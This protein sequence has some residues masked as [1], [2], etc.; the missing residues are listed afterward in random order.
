[1]RDV[2]GLLL[3]DEEQT[4]VRSPIVPQTNLKAQVASDSIKHQLKEATMQIV[5]NISPPMENNYLADVEKEK[6][7]GEEKIIDESVEKLIQ[8]SGKSFQTESVQKRSA[9]EEESLGMTVSKDNWQQLNLTGRSSRVAHAEKVAKRRQTVDAKQMTQINQALEETKKCK[10]KDAQKDS[11]VDKLGLEKRDNESKAD[12]VSRKTKESDR[13]KGLKGGVKNEK[14]TS[15]GD[16]SRLVVSSE[17]SDES[18]SISS[19]SDDGEVSKD[20]IMYS[21]TRDSKTEE[22]NVKDAKCIKKRELSSTIDRPVVTR[23]DSEVTENFERSTKVLEAKDSNVI[24]LSSSARRLSESS[25][26]EVNGTEKIAKVSGEKVELS[27]RESTVLPLSKTADGLDT[28][29]SID[30]VLQSDTISEMSAKNLTQTATEKNDDKEFAPEKFA[31]EKGDVVPE[32]QII[33]VENV[34]SIESHPVGNIESHPENISDDY[35]EDKQSAM[36]PPFTSPKIEQERNNPDLQSGILV[37]SMT[38]NKA[39][40]TEKE[41]TELPA[42]DHETMDEVM[43]NVGNSEVVASDNGADTSVGNKTDENTIGIEEREWGDVSLHLSDV[44]VSPSQLAET[45]FSMTPPRD[46]SSQN[47]VSTPPPPGHE[48][49]CKSVEA[50]ES[51]IT[52]NNSEVDLINLNRDAE[53]SNSLDNDKMQ[54]DRFISKKLG[55]NDPIFLIKNVVIQS[56]EEKSIPSAEEEPVIPDA[57]ENETVLAACQLRE[58]NVDMLKENEKVLKANDVLVRQL[59]ISGPPLECS[60]STDSAEMLLWTDVSF[61]LLD[62]E[63][64]S[65]DLP[66]SPA[67]EET[68]TA[69]LQESWNIPVEHSV[70]LGD[71][72]EGAVGKII[73]DPDLESLNFMEAVAEELGHNAEESTS[74]MSCNDITVHKKNE[75]MIKCSVGL[76]LELSEMQCELGDNVECDKKSD[77]QEN[78]SRG[79]LT[80]SQNRSEK[81]PEALKEDLNVKMKE[82]EP[83]I[84]VTKHA[85]KKA[86]SLE[87]VVEGFC[88][89]MAR[90]MDAIT[91]QES[92]AL[93]SPLYAEVGQYDVAK[94]GSRSRVARSKTRST[95]GRKRSKAEKEFEDDG[96]EIGKEEEIGGTTKAK[97]ELD[98]SEGRTL[99]KDSDKMPNSFDTAVNIAGK[100]DIVIS[101]LTHKVRSLN[102]D[103]IQTTSSSIVSQEHVPQSSSEKTEGTPLKKWRQLMKGDQ[104]EPGPSQEPQQP[105]TSES[106]SVQNEFTLCSNAP[107]DGIK[108]GCNRLVILGKESLGTPKSKRPRSGFKSQ[109]K[110][111][112]R[113]ILSIVRSSGLDK[114]Y[115]QPQRDLQDIASHVNLDNLEHQRREKIKSF[116]THDVKSKT[117]KLNVEEIEVDSLVINEVMLSSKAGRKNQSFSGSTDK[118]FQVETE[119]VVCKNI[120]PNVGALME[121]LTPGEKLNE[122]RAPGTVPLS[123]SDSEQGELELCISDDEGSKEAPKCNDAKILEAKMKSDDE[124]SMIACG[125]FDLLTGADESSETLSCVQPSES[126][127]NKKLAV[128]LGLIWKTGI[129]SDA[130]LDGEAGDHAFNNAFE[131]NE[132]ATGH[133]SDQIE[134]IETVQTERQNEDDDEDL[135]PVLCDSTSPTKRSTRKRFLTELHEKRDENDTVKISPLKKKS[136]EASISS[137]NPRR[138]SEL[139]SITSAVDEVEIKSEPAFN[140]TRPWSQMTV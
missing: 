87:V 77:F 140:D 10:T 13:N 29:S 121:D 15:W 12:E 104:I 92:E 5:K 101:E 102:S 30:S 65:L 37:P 57:V 124:N 115:E 39:A 16:K 128:N 138:R 107:G 127:P 97:R 11:F 7:R 58:V 46:N 33:S 50:K 106:R 47:Q 69:A 51:D 84:D 42:L 98:R 123:D 91:K 9:V 44:E 78:T 135:H 3:G 25:D 63:D 73:E 139:Q 99:D 125:S 118:H 45:F 17:D 94:K 116:S 114:F 103:K 60:F 40:S 8:L 110:E 75:G 36:E 21:G 133:I 43:T 32:T 93:V 14:W 131:S 122:E 132:I 22:Q 96:S 126:T 54:E 1:M 24:Q 72:D 48:Y 59:S 82:K 38:A 23:L 111:A 130:V 113:E 136:K 27:C 117:Q 76:S 86:G 68:S 95:A 49:S 129:Q 105:P 112:K 109:V 67:S 70:A 6:Q 66:L 108:E 26:E 85:E 90:D 119:Q 19:D 83:E 71:K 34:V 61:D 81:K 137:K 120:N 88:I 80:R 35:I 74:N 100:N 79:R 18:S 64:I 52:G 4:P 31:P 53:S 134:Q 62:A 2:T 41:I 20:S 56:T 55:T 89:K 28:L